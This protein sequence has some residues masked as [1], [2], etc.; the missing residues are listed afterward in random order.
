MNLA[1]VKWTL[2]ICFLFNFIHQTYSVET[3]SEYC[4]FPQK[5]LNDCSFN[6]TIQSFLRN[7]T[8][9]TQMN[10]PND[11]R[12]H[13]D[14]S[15]DKSLIWIYSIVSV[16]VISIA[17][18]LTV[19]I[20][21]HIT[22]RV[23]DQAN[24]FLI[25]LAVGC[26]TGDAFLHLIPHTF[27]SSHDGEEGKHD[28][29][30]S[31]RINVYRGLCA[32]LSLYLFFL[33]EHLMSMKREIKLEKKRNEQG[34]GD[35][36]PPSNT[37][38]DEKNVNENKEQSVTLLDID[39]SIE[40]KNKTEKEG[41]GEK[42]EDVQKKV[43]HDHM[44]LSKETEHE[45]R[46]CQTPA[47][48][49]RALTKK[50]CPLHIRQKKQNVHFAKKDNSD[51]TLITEKNSDV[52]CLKHSHHS[53][54]VPTSI[55]SIAVVV[56]LGDGL[57]NF[58]DGLAIGGSFSNSLTTGISTAVAVLCHELPHEIGNFAVLLR[59]GMTFRNAVFYNLIS[60]FLCLLGVICGVLLGQIGN[61]SQW[62][63]PFIAGTFFYIALVDM[64]PELRNALSEQRRILYFI[65]Q[66]IGLYIGASIMFIVAYYEHDL[67]HLFSK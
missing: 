50:N 62:I 24:Q 33:I 8:S 13:G 3:E 29:S 46:L 48:N 17:G 18:L 55:S 66:N 54:A 6:S 9:V 52:E 36:K 10:S 26:L 47:E 20:V 60:S 4:S 28:H 2:S 56:I 39:Q 63:F 53:H 7:L 37:M 27:V 51:N 58:A 1:N 22:R 23:F 61:A 41:H 21:P 67:L 43:C 14:V 11:S 57:H 65:L 15:I 5:L 44:N 40:K 59:A 25:A 32:L 45:Q 35:E 16:I 64:L 12:I 49:L 19:V 34:I 42:G 31:E 30:E 38:V